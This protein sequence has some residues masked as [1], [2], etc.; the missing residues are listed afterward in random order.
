MKKGITYQE[1]LFRASAHCS[2]GEKC[3]SDITE[4]LRKWGI[5][6]DNIH[7][8]IDYLVDEKYIDEKRYC[9][10]FVNDKIRFDGWGKIKIEYTLK[11]K[12][13]PTSYI[14]EAIGDI[15]DT[16]YRKRLEEIL[17][18]K[19]KSI[20]GKDEQEI[21]M[22][23]MRFAASRGFEPQ[24]IYDFLENYEKEDFYHND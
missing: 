22:K 23:L 2:S 8:I 21:K 5:T 15:D 1:A 4:K 19:R 10:S 3:R 14:H 12:G 24:H 20:T 17:T 13:I 7:R 16:L 9:H 6:S 18:R 11:Q